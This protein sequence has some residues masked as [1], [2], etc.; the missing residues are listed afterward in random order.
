MKEKKIRVL[1]ELPV[2][3][4]HY[5]LWSLKERRAVCTVI[6]LLT[7]YSFPAQQRIPTRLKA[8]NYAEA[9]AWI[10][11]HGGEEVKFG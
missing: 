6:K 4:P 10:A 11:A 3:G 2:Y 1:V 8:L 9:L 7:V 5:R